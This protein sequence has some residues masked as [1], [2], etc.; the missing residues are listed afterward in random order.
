MAFFLKPVA[1]LGRGVEVDE[2]ADFGGNLVHRIGHVVGVVVAAE[3]VLVEPH[4]LLFEGH[5]R[6]QVADALFD[7]A[8]GVLVGGLSAPVP[9][10]RPEG[11]GQ[12][13]SDNGYFFIGCACYLNTGLSERRIVAPGSLFLRSKTTMRF[14]FFGEDF[15]RNEDRLLFLLVPERAE[16]VPVD[17]HLAHAPSRHVEVNGS[18]VRRTVELPAPETGRVARAEGFELEGFGI[19]VAHFERVIVQP[20]IVSPARRGFAE[21]S[22][23]VVENLRAVGDAADV[24]DVELQCVLAGFCLQ[25][26]RFSVVGQ[27]SL[28]HAVEV[29]RGIVPHVLQFERGLPCGNGDCG[30]V[31]DVS[32]FHPHIAH[33]KQFVGLADLAVNL[34]QRGAFG[35]FQLLRPCPEQAGQQAAEQ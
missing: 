7:G 22:F 20:A 34:R 21:E 13:Q 33:R 9:G 32:E 16:V 31:E 28:K 17:P 14:P 3:R 2:R 4:D 25:D 18:F 10:L 8:S 35:H 26:Q 29:N 30:L 23:R 15:G 5:P 11:G 1:Q 12:Q 27:G 6:Q 24:F 19:G